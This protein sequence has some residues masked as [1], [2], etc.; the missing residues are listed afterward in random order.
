M[1]CP[2]GNL[3]HDADDCAVRAHALINIRTLLLIGHA[4]ML[5]CLLVVVRLMAPM[6]HRSTVQVKYYTEKLEL[7]DASARWTSEV[8]QHYIRGLHWV[9]QYYYRG[10]ASWDWFYPYHYAPMAQDMRQLSDIN[11]EA[12]EFRLRCHQRI[13]ACGKLVKPLLFF[14]AHTRRLCLHATASQYSIHT[15]H[16]KKTLVAGWSTRAILTTVAC[17]VCWGFLLILLVC[18]VSFSRG[19]PFRPYEQLL[20]VMPPASASLLPPAFRWLMTDARSPIVDF[21]PEKFDVDMEGKRAEWE[22]I[23][24]VPFVSEARLLEAVASVPLDRCARP[25]SSCA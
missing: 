24:K 19:R 17:C 2:A 13:Q 6:V 15:V 14:P 22:G 16:T 25:N 23:V 11:G 3:S 8:V 21:Y 12:A 20:A 9:L 1:V 7:P 18:A 5:A 4:A 10:V